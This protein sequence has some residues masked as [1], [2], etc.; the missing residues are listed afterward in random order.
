MP[1]YSLCQLDVCTSDYFRGY[2]NDVIQVVVD[3]NS[4]YQMI[5]EDCLDIY[6]ATDHIENLDVDAYKKQ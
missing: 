5:K 3:G 1:K 4:T 6:S 2:H